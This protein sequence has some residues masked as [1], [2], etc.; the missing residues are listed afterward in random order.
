MP[1]PAPLQGCSSG[2]L[3]LWDA[4]PDGQPRRGAECQRWSLVEINDAGKAEQ[5]GL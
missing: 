2:M 5:L 3:L 1:P 4:A